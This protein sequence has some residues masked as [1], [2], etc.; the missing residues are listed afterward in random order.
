MLVVRQRTKDGINAQSAVAFFKS[1]K[2]ESSMDEVIGTLVG[3][4]Y[5]WELLVKARA[6]DE[7]DQ[8]EKSRSIEGKLG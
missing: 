6:S 8:L 1:I 7:V 2:E 4:T 5:K 3:E